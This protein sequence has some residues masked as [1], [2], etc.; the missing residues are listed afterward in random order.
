MFVIE[1]P[2]DEPE[3]SSVF[4]KAMVVVVSHPELPNFKKSKQGTA[5]QSSAPHARPFRMLRNLGLTAFLGC[6]HRATD[7]A[8]VS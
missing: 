5:G 6:H 8:S 3:P 2:Q 4:S 1:A 7:S